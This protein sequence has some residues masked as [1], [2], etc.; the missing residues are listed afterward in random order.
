MILRDRVL[1]HIFGHVDADERLLVVEHKVRER[2]GELGLADAGGAEEHERADGAVGVGDARARALDR[3]GDLLHRFVLADD[4]LLRASSSMRESFS[5]SSSSMRETGMPVQLE[6][7][8]AMSL[9]VISSLRMRRVD[10]SFLSRFCLLL[11]LALEAGIS[12]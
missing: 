4:A 8:P 10:C 3:V 1:L 7:T 12:P 9:S 6:T 2:S 11:E 5:A